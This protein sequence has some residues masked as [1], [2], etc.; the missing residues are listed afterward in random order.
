MGRVLRLEAM[1]PLGGTI[2]FQCPVSVA[3]TW[4]LFSQFDYVRCE[5]DSLVRMLEIERRWGR[6]FERLLSLWEFRGAF[7]ARKLEEELD[8]LDERESARHG[9]GSARGADLFELAAFLQTSM[10]QELPEDVRG[11]S[12]FAVGPRVNGRKRYPLPRYLFELA[13][14]EGDGWRL[15]LVRE[16]IVL[17]D[18]LLAFCGPRNAA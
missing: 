1:R 13:S 14:R 16:N 11:R 4:N 7:A 3:V 10:R 2:V 15:R 6:G 12:I 9:V 5:V 18:S 8:K 17:S